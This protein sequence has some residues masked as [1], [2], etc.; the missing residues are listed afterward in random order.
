MYQ[1]VTTH[2]LN[3]F[4]KHGSGDGISEK[5]PTRKTTRG[6]NVKTLLSDAYFAA[7][8]ESA[9]DVAFFFFLGMRMSERECLR[10]KRLR[11][12]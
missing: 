4:G 8:V 11:S 7:A 3:G 6:K 12:T 9:M 2:R 10:W 1:S 5:I